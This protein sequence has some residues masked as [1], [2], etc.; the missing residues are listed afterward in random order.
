[1]TKIMK[2]LLAVICSTCCLSYVYAAD[3]QM[4]GGSQNA[5]ASESVANAKRSRVWTLTEYAC[6]KGTR[7]ETQRVGLVSVVMQRGADSQPMRLLGVED[8]KTGEVAFVHVLDTDCSGEQPIPA[9]GGASLA[10]THKSRGEEEYFYAISSQGECLRA[11][12]IRS[13]GQLFPVDMS[14]RMQDC[15]RE[16]RTWLSQAAKW[17]AQ[18][19]STSKTKP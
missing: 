14:T 16:V 12:Q 3:P 1:M 19:N 15:E 17:K 11:F 7:Q 8:K 9:Q 13:L 5:A 10:L 18:A 2:T 4:Q 6:K